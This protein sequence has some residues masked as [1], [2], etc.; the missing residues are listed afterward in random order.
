MNSFIFYEEVRNNKRSN[1]RIITNNFLFTEK[2]IDTRSANSNRKISDETWFLSTM[3]S[4]ARSRADG[5]SPLTR[6]TPDSTLQWSRHRV[7][8]STAC[9]E[10]ESVLLRD[11]TNRTWRN[12]PSWNECKLIKIY[13]SNNPFFQKNNLQR[14]YRE[15]YTYKT[16]YSIFF[17]HF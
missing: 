10:R 12:F 14:N 9:N 6:F 13:I 16:L 1:S 5:D 4:L 17:L 2:F 11:R 15:R 3:Y 8:S 7:G